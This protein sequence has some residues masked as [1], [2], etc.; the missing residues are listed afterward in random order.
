M[1]GWG[2]H[3]QKKLKGE[4]ASLRRV[5]FHFPLQRTSFHRDSGWKE[6]QII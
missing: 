6:P 5:T 3:T 2:F 1:L 4:I